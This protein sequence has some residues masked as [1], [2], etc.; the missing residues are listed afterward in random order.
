[1]PSKAW[2]SGR[3]SRVASLQPAYRRWLLGQGHGHRGCRAAEVVA[4]LQTTLASRKWALGAD[5]APEAA[6][7]QAWSSATARR[8]RSTMLSTGFSS[9]M[10]VAGSSTTRRCACPKPNWRNGPRAIRPQ[11]ARYAALFAGDPLPLRMAIYFPLQGKLHELSTG[12]GPLE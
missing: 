12:L 3:P 6:A 7:E 8:L 10:A 1:L 4:A 9:P 11:L 2:R 5:R